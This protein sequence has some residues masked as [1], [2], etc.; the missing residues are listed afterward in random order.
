[1]TKKLSEENIKSIRA[2]HAAGSRPRD[3]AKAYGVS[4]TTVNQILNYKDSYALNKK[5]LVN[6]ASAKRKLA[7]IQTYNHKHLRDSRYKLTDA[8]LIAIRTA[9]AAGEKIADLAR[10]YSVS[11]ALI[12]FVVG[13]YAYKN[14]ASRNSRYRMLVDN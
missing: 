3:L 7:K 11:K 5:T 2:S 14:V 1:M 13:R 6:D 10:A 9:H 8:D 4:Y 12:Y